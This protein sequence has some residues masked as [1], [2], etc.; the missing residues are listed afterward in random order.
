VPLTTGFRLGPYEIVSAIG[1]G[2]MGEV[3]RA[4]DTRLNRDVAV[5]VLPDLL[6]SDSERLARFEREAQVL[7][8]LNHP[9]I[10][11]IYGVEDVLTG[12]G[13]HSRA[14][15]MELVEGE[16][17]AARIARGPVPIDE[18]LPVARQIADALE[19]AHERGIVHRDLKPG[20]IKVRADGTVKVLD[21][22]LAK[23]LDATEAPAISS[24]P[25]TITSPATQLGVILGTAAYMAPEQ[26]KGGAVDKRADIWAFGC[27]LFE[28]LT[29]SRPF[30]GD[31]VT[32][33]LASIL[34]A[35]PDWTR[36][37]PE[38]P[39]AIRALLRRS[40]VKNP[41]NR[42]RDIGDAR[43]ALDEMA[44]GVE[45]V[46]ATDRGRR[47]LAWTLAPWVGL[48]VAGVVIV[49]LATLREKSPPQPLRKW[50]VS[51]PGMQRGLGIEPVIAP[52]GGSIAYIADGRVLIRQ[53]DQ[54]VPR[55]V[56]APAGGAEAL[57]WSRDGAFLGY[58]AGRKLW[59]VSRNG[60]ESSALCAIPESGRALAATWGADDTIVFSAWRGSLYRVST[61]GG[62]ATVLL[63]ANPAAEV[64]FHR[65]QFL[66]DG[67]RLVFI[68][69]PITGPVNRIESL[70]DGVRA[71]V[72]DAGA[73]AVSDVDVSPTGHLLFGRTGASQGVWAVPFELSSATVRGEP[74][75]V[76]LGAASFSLAADGTLSYAEV[77]RAGDLEQLVW[78][79]RA[80]RV[81]Q[82][83]GMPRQSIAGPAL[84]PD[85]RR[86]AFAGEQNDNV[87]IWIEDLERGGAMRVTSTAD[88]EA[89]P[90]W[91]PR[92][93]LLTFVRLPTSNTLQAH[94]LIQNVAEGIAE[95]KIVD[96]HTPWFSP[97]GLATRLL[98][99]DSASLWRPPESTLGRPESARRV[100]LAIPNFRI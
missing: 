44:T 17:L 12:G 90:A 35:D 20:N 50:E 97:D 53:L 58:G 33:T 7:A 21:F 67:R 96:G 29:G 14:L 79:D 70:A 13:P 78:L 62:A 64:D 82:T 94:I 81:I 98:S 45:T 37:P 87:D 22:G 16:D 91:S 43:I 56:A 39:P 5:K 71:T 1:A 92:G 9:H 3:Y 54:L 100:S 75:L 95:R 74:V 68:T 99:P 93:D 88:A 18:A 40:L 31:S 46:P 10:A 63:A 55:E 24:T 69:H 41:M 34:R 6:A 51:M 8:S 42:L 30:D 27:V 84:S 11:H 49:A 65:P 66:P 15:V 85:G 76:A 23:A 61:K 36:L 47:T 80:G 28:M 25:P 2:G 32:E 89:Q 38:G 57:F 48:I 60:G 59:K 86:V 72:F 83:I 73:D 77:S 26:A 52:D 19:A 4:R